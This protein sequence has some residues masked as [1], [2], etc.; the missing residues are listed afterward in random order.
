MIKS[1]LSLS[2]AALAFS[3]CLEL[4]AISVLPT[5][6]ADLQSKAES[7]FRG[8]V[9]TVR[10]A[11]DPAR[12]PQTPYTWVTFRVL[13]TY[14]GTLPAEITLRFLGGT[15]KEKTLR[16]EGAP[17]FVAG[18]DDIVFV[19]QNGQSFCPLVSAH[20]GRYRISKDKSGVE[21]IY[22][23]D[24]RALTDLNQIARETSGQATRSNARTQDTALSFQAFVEALRAH[25]PAP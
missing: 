9:T 11:P 1:W 21:R 5:R 4:H 24:G 16:I 8:K 14:K 15:L 13:E 10:Y 25:P 19:E 12:D 17:T 2:I 22:L 3:V 7:I 18:D 6:F 23:N 20:Y